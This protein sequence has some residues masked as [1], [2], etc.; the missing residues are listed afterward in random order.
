MQKRNN[1][2]NIHNASPYSETQRYVS[3]SDTTMGSHWIPL[4]QSDTCVPLPLYSCIVSAGSPGSQSHTCVCRLLLSQ[5]RQAA[6]QSGSC[7]LLLLLLQTL[8]CRPMIC[9]ILLP[10]PCLLLTGCCEKYGN[11][12]LPNTERAAS[13]NNSFVFL[14]CLAGNFCFGVKSSSVVNNR[15]GGRL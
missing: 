11:T 5:A 14:L 13:N 2:D 8:H 15:G 6:N 4:I 1:P 3:I 10:A 9:Q 7:V 12:F